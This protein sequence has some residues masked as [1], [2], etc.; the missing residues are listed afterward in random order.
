VL[1]PKLKELSD[2]I[3]NRKLRKKVLDFLENP[4]F[5][6][7]GKVYSGPS[8][9]ISPGGL[10]HH[11]TYEGGYVEHVAATAKLA[12]AL[13]DVVEEV[14][15]GKV[16]RDLVT[17][18]ILLHDIFK[19]VTYAVD[20]KGDFTSAAIAD[21]MDHIS[22]A[23]SELVRRDFPVELVHIVAAH[24]GSYGPIKP[25]T[26]EALVLHLADN[27]DSQLNGQVL[28]AAGFLTRKATGEY[29]TKLTSKEAF[30]I[31]HSKATEGWKGVEKTVKKIK[32]KREPQ[33][34]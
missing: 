31:V 34:T 14:Y 33:K 20:E 25:R 8:F 15:G 12:L 10:A 1:N 19:P 27:A 23:T 28:D 13:C 16:D 24:Y 30:E 26:I 2:K 18:G 4:T 6:L 9:D 32:Q 7:D 11:H 21:Y 17:A 22:L 3:R 29:M 5:K